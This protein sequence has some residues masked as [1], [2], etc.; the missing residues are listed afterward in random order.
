MTIEEFKVKAMQKVRCFFGYHDYHIP[1]IGSYGVAVR[2]IFG[3]N[4]CRH[5]NKFVIRDIFV[6]T[7]LT[8]AYEYG[9]AEENNRM[10]AYSR[11]LEEIYA[12]YPGKRPKNN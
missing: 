12:V 1:Q 11:G 9:V 10:I 3:G 7:L 8:Q 4:K 6:G 5:C 2:W